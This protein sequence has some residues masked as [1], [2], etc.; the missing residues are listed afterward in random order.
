MRPRLV[1]AHTA[2]IV[3]AAR[4]ASPT[5]RI[6]VDWTES[7]RQPSGGTARTMIAAATAPSTHVEARDRRSTGGAVRAP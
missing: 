3:E 1:R 5:A 4:S 2:N 6:Q 7:A